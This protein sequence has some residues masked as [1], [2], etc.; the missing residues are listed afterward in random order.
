MLIQVR[1]TSRVL[2]R[3]LCTFPRSPVTMEGLLPQAFSGNRLNR[4]AERDP[5]FI[6]SVIPE[7]SI[8][9]VAGRKVGVHSQREGSLRGYKLAWLKAKDLSDLGIQEEQGCFKAH[10]GLPAEVECHPILLGQEPDGRWR[11]GLDASPLLDASPSPL[12]KC[13]QWEDLRSLMTTLPATELSVAG[14]AVALLTWHL[15]HGFCGRCGAPTLPVEAGTRRQCTANPRHKEYPR[16]DPVA[17]M[18]VESMDGERAL[19]GASKA[20][21]SLGPVLTCL[22]GFIEQCESIEEAVRERCGKRP[23]LLWGPSHI[24]GSQPWPIGRAGSC[25][26]MIGCVAKAEEEELRPNL[27]EMAEVRWV[28][29]PDLLK[30]L[31]AAGDPRNP[32]LSGKGSEDNGLGFYIPPSY[33]IATTL[34]KPGP[35]EIPPGSP[36]CEVEILLCTWQSP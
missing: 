27:E 36:R 31:A 2:C 7:S 18:I 21:R 16:T 22:S 9:L 32:L 5:N 12:E 14:Q 26:L 8:L 30:A 34:S 10:L 33:A 17:I 29:K 15:N 23:A 1:V 25:E 13:L 19:L 4:T 20:V 6:R 35:P 28:S 3:F 24:L 11:L